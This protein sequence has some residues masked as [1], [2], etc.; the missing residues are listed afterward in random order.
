MSRVISSIICLLLVSGDLAAQR[1]PETRVRYL[2][3]DGDDWVQEAEF[4]MVQRADPW[5]IV[6]T[7]GRGKKRL[8]VQTNY[9]H[10]KL[11][12]AA[13][14]TLKEEGKKDKSLFL[15]TQNGKTQVFRDGFETQK[16]MDIPPGVIV[17]SAPDW[18]DVF[19]LSRRYDYAQGGKQ[20]FMALWAHPDQPAQLLN[21]SIERQGHDTI[22]HDGKDVKL[23]R[24]TIELRGKSQ[25]AVWA[26]MD[27]TMVRLIPLP[28]KEKQR[29]GLILE[30]FEKSGAV[31]LTPP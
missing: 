4:T 24:F 23:T 1:L 9:D 28:A 21:L 31:E 13:K 26:T 6:S 25:Y 19:L 22:R 3:P 29:N 12:R 30:G 16:F 5:E 7:T 18:S 27:G 10:E 14:I 8:I 15:K 20:I 2:S 11:L 17:T